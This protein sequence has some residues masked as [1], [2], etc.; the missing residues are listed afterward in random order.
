MFIGHF[1]VAFAGKKFAPKA[2]LGALL[3]GAL[4]ADILW[5]SLVAVG[6]EHV[7]ISPGAT[8]YTPLEF[9]SYPWS[10]SLLM[11]II[12]GG[13][14][15]AYCR[16]RPNGREIGT[17]LAILVVS[18]W[19]LDF[20]THRPDMPLFPGGSKYGLGLW[21]NVTATMVVEIVMF[22]AG[23]A[24]YASATE[25]RDGIGRWGFHGLAAL[26]LVFFVL[27]SLDPA[28]P[29]SVRMIWI[30]AL[31]ATAIILIWAEWFDRHRTAG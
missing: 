9:V 18:H 30:S 5:P 14:F 21:N 3:L 15:A 2:S 8:V 12:W 11:L 1:A 26:L 20:V 23:L 24:M 17:A 31:I 10:H 16:K 29:P 13:L 7:R 22:V 25:A 19:F 6:A 27:D 4:F 28:P